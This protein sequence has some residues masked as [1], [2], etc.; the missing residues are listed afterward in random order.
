VLPRNKSEPGRQLTAVLEA[1]CIA[2]GRHQS[3]GRDRPHT[4]DACQFFAG[5]AFAVPQLDLNFQ[6]ADVPIELLQVIAKPLQ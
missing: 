1:L 3:A 4:W 6:L 5:S 2:N